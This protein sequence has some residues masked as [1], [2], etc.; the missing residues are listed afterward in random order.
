MYI[1]PQ[2]FKLG[3]KKSIKNIKCLVES[4]AC[5]KYSINASCQRKLIQI[6]PFLL[7]VYFLEQ[8]LPG[9]FCFGVWTPHSW[10]EK[11]LNEWDCLLGSSSWN[12]L[13]TE[14]LRSRRMLAATLR[15]WVLSKK[16]VIRVS[17]SIQSHV[18]EFSI[19]CGSSESFWVTPGSALCKMMKNGNKWGRVVWK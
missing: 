11:A 1:L 12:I 5:I 9:L 10:N 19:P 6:F 16:L 14:V 2:F 15:P 13:F 4:L 7:K 17:N 8:Q 3:G 18:S